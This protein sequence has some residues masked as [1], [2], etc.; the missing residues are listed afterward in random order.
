[1]TA[2]VKGNG[3]TSKGNNGNVCLLSVGLLLKERICSQREQSLSLKSILFARVVSLCKNG[4]QIFQVEAGLYLFCLY[5][6]L[7]IF[8]Y[9]GSCYY[10]L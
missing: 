7:N 1:M 8:S 5:G 2:K 3:N 10:D 9:S 4:C 6:I